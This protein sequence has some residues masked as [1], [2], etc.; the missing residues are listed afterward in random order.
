[1]AAESAVKVCVRIRPVVA[2]EERA[3]SEKAQPVQL[4]WKADKKSVCQID[5][6][7]SSKCFSFDR[8]FTAEESTSQL[9][10]DI[11]KPLV[12]STVEGYNGTIFAYGQTSSGKTFTMMGSDRNPG[13][14]PLAVDDVF[15]TIKNFPNKEFLLRVSYME[16][17]NETVTDLLV[18]SWKRKPLEVRETIDKT[19][20][21]AELT[22]E[23]V[24][25][26]A[27]AL[28]WIRKGET[29]RHYGKTKM[30]QWSSRSH[31]IFRMILESR[32][33]TDPALG[34]NADGAIFV[35]HLNLVDLAGS[36]R[37]SQTGAEG[38]RLKE[39]CNINL[40]LFTLGQVIKKLTD[41]SQKGFTNYRDSKLTRILQNSLGGNAK[42]VI[43][44]TIT[45]VSLD[46]TLSTLQFASTAKKMKNDPHVTEVLGD[47]AL[48]K[49]Y[50]N[51]ILDLKCQLNKVSS[52]TH[53]AV[54]EKE[55]LAQLLEE[56]EQLQREQEDRIRTLTKLLVTSSNPISYPKMPKRR[57][58]WGGKMVKHTQP[59]A[60]N[61][62]G[63]PRMNM[64]FGWKRKADRLFSSE[65]DEDFYPHWEIPEEPSDEMEMSQS[66]VTVR[67]FGESPTGL[68]S[69]DGICAQSEKI[70]NLDWQFE[71]DSQRREEAV[72]KVEMLESRV[73][74][75]LLHVQS[76]A[77]QKLEA[78][79]KTQATEVTLQN[80]VKE[81][82]D[83]LEKMQTMEQR[84]AD[85]QFQ[86][87]SE[88]KLK[89]EAVLQ[90]QAAEHS[91]VE[92]KRVLETETQQKLECNDM[93]KLKVSDPERQLEEQKHTES[94]QMRKCLADSVQL[95]EFLAS[96][97]EK[98]IAERD[99]LKQE[100]GIFLEHTK[101]LEKEKAEELKE[102][103]D[104]NEF[105]RLENKL[106]K[107]HEIKGLTEELQSVL[108]EK[109]QL[110]AEK[111]SSAEKLEKLQCDLMAINEERNQLDMV[112]KELREEKKKLQ[113]Q[114]E[115]NNQMGLPEDLQSV[116]AEK[117]QLLAE[118]ESSA[119]KLEK[120]QC[121]LMAINEERNQLDMVVKELREE[122]KKLQTQLEENN[123]MDD[124]PPV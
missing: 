23:L 65:T 92:L 119:E 120:L 51:E 115:E 75:L 97:K 110:L 24:T 90:M 44:S 56:K 74:E 42:T 91:L 69:S 73:A 37:A 18:D 108:A 2:R 94:D 64:T 102:L 21:V 46:E 123:Q 53:T 20:Y 62:D 61:D 111:E 30:N 71:I 104:L 10:M 67:S 9:Y 60:F 122:K 48:L 118:K 112:V 36:E 31:T 117:D 33:R 88:T 28:A 43:I 16:I 93:L 25:S 8:V 68:V 38:A 7:N 70:S 29:N 54:T 86:L 87:Q 85:L 27:Q 45:P 79:K 83:A 72:K 4:F 116:L 41:E 22:E 13:V 105:T 47:G 113:A 1:M 109:D 96:E 99:Y 12:V 77:S 34:E 39:G 89:L 17:Y 14:I 106:I 58:T 98:V 124:S 52:V 59:S 100:L 121:D 35:S 81:K 6:G 78:V 80:E 57:V 32:E 63:M 50:R 49:R 66:S 40:S 5:D 76:E 103:K 26:S 3:A 11:A 114:H 15:Q 19:I 82:L 107:E 84:I 55:V 95:C 101:R